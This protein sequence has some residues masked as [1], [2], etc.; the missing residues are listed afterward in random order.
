MTTETTDIVYDLF[1]SYVEPDRD[2]VD[3]YLLDAL[4]AAGVTYCSE[5]DFDLGK[6]RVIEI[7]T[8]MKRSKYTLLVL[9]PAYMVDNGSQFL[10]SL[11]QSYGMEQ[12]DTWPV[13]PLIRQPVDLPSRLTQLERLDATDPERWPK[14][15]ERLC[16]QA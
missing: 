8:S 14:V 3:K 6:P 12:A 9:S 15:I 13:I 16:A 7:E 4:E 10:V 5:A 11:G 1:V 2:W